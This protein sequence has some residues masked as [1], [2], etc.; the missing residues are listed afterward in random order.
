MNR[1][2]GVFDSG[3]GGLSLLADLMR[4]L[5]RE[6][7]LYLADNAS[8]P[9]GNRPREE[10]GALAA[11][12]ADFLLQRDAKCIVVAC[13]T[14][15]GTCVKDLRA[16]SPVPV[17]GVEPALKPALERYGSRIGVLATRATL[18]CP[19]FRALLARLG[20]ERFRLFPSAELARQIEEHFLDDIEGA[21][22]PCL[23]DV[24]HTDLSCLVLGCTHYVLAEDAVARAA[25]LPTLHGNG[26]TV[27]NVCRTLSG[28]GAP[29]A[30]AA[31]E[32][33]LRLAVTRP[34]S[35]PYYAAVLRRIGLGGALREGE[36]TALH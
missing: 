34:G 10:I 31:P 4:A 27:R 36:E 8:V 1:P 15:T 24:R 12:C 6:N 11:R 13:N 16:K 14:I 21:V 20:E 30:S 18:S 19:K 9:Y 2:I 33:T 35:L 29:D 5:P 22:S 17:F 25:G 3:I 26:G 28:M 7:F 32:R 23:E